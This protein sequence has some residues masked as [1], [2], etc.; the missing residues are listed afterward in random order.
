MHK[1]KEN[2]LGQVFGKWTVICEAI[3]ENGHTRW[4]CQCECG[5]KNWVYTNALKKGTS[6]GCLKCSKGSTK[7]NMSHTKTYSTWV[8]MIERCHNQEHPFYKWYGER[9]IY[10]CKEWIKSFSNFL[11]DMGEKPEGLTLDR[12]DNESGYHKDNCRWTTRK[13]QQRN[14]RNSIKIG[15]IHENWV[16][17]HR[18]ED[19]KKYIIHCTDCKRERIILSCNFRKAKSCKCKEYHYEN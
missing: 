2:I 3:P 11:K 16:V 12:I 19:Q 1:N 10:V 15:E 17:L 18:I 4:I 14:R 7:H 6:K 9:G 5:L 8:Q 13:E